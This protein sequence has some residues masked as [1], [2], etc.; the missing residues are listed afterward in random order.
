MAWIGQFDFSIANDSKRY[1]RYININPYK[2]LKGPI[3]W[4]H[5]VSTIHF[6][7]NPI[8]DYR[9]A[10]FSV[11]HRASENWPNSLSF[12]LTSMHTQLSVWHRSTTALTGCRKFVEQQKEI[13]DR[14][15]REREFNVHGPHSLPITLL[16]LKD[17]YYR[18][19]KHCLAVAWLAG[20]VQRPLSEHYSETFFSI[21]F[22]SLFHAALVRSW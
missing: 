11:G 17:T 9:R 10:E 15:E 2:S 21:I 18:S 19:V 7:W 3:P 1:G 5:R 20:S 8:I 22:E 13:A 14:S 4:S 16:I 12:S 6:L